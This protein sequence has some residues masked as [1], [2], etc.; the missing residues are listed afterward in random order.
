MAYALLRLSKITENPLYLDASI[1][2]L[3][4]VKGNAGGLD[5]AYYTVKAAEFARDNQLLSIFST[6][7]GKVEQIEKEKQNNFWLNGLLGEK[8]QTPVVAP[9][10]PSA[11]GVPAA[12]IPFL[13]LAII[14]ILAGLLSFASPCCLPTL[15]AFAACIAGSSKE[16]IRGRT[17]AFVLGMAAT[18]VLLGMSASVAGSFLRS[19]LTGVS[20]IF[21]ILIMLFGLY[22]LSGRGLALFRPLQSRPTSYGGSF[23]FG[24]TLGVTRA[25]CI[26]PVL[27]TVFL[28]ASTSASVLQGGTLL[29]LYSLGLSIPFLLFG[30]Y[31]GKV[32]TNSRVWKI[33]RGREMQWNLFGL[34]FSIHTTTLVTGIL[35]LLLGY[36]IFNGTLY[37]LS[38]FSVNTS[39]QKWLFQLEA[40]LLHSIR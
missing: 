36:L 28:L 7:K 20:Q 5:D 32:N 16:S 26:G 24:A 40:W 38:R 15:P 30:L 4:T 22:T 35:F 23:L 18:F 39:F 33:L 6:S 11:E 34:R 12:Q 37:S 29:L 17:V 1:K 31:L 2:T 10:Q 14:A 25:P 27:V 9:F 13:I 8:K 19:H 21:G 3:G